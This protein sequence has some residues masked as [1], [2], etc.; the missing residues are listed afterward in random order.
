MIGRPKGINY[1]LQ[2]HYVLQNL[3]DK[4]AET[5]HYDYIPLYSNLIIDSLQIIKQ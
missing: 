1:L 4:S 3:P 2:S 5:C